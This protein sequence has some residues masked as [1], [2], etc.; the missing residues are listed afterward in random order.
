MRRVLRLAALIAVAALAVPVSI[1]AWEYLW[2]PV[3]DFPEP[4]PFA[5]TQW[6]NPYADAPATWVRANF[7]AHTIA[8]G[9][10]TNGHQ[11]PAQLDSTFRALGFG[12]RGI[13]NYHEIDT[14]FRADSAYLPSYEYGYAIRKTHRLAIGART[15]NWLDF[16]L[17]QSRHHKQFIIDRVRPTTALLALNHPRMRHGHTPDDFR[18]L[19]NY[20]FVEALN[21]FGDSLDE[22]DS[23]LSTGHAAW[24]LGDDDTH[25]I[26]KGDQLAVRWTV[27]ATHSTRADSVIAALRAGRHYAVRGHLGRMDNGVRTVTMVGDTLT[28]ALDRRAASIRFIGDSGRVLGTVTDRSAASWIATRR[29]SY[30]RVEV[31]SDSTDFFLNPVV[32]WDGRALPQPR[33]ELNTMA[34]WLVRMAIA[35]AY[36]AV[37]F[38]ARLVWRRRRA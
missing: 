13:S 33:P 20:D 31:R 25:D 6:F 19:A 11:T 30:V 9:G 17:G 37:L 10:L 4:R 26:A 36:L 23:A 24:L 3:Y 34:T 32:R 15:V 35:L 5:G 38:G 21:P 28:I 16:P 1:V 2:T 27:I 7:H 22:W 12:V 14:T 8:W 29:E 18:W